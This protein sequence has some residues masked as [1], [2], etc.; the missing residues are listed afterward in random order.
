MQC[1]EFRKKSKKRLNIKTHY[2]CLSLKGYNVPAP[3]VPPALLPH[4]LPVGHT[5]RAS[6]IIQLLK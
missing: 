6:E 4:P 3:F 2:N 1:P 5:G